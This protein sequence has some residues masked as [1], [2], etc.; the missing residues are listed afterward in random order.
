MSDSQEQIIEA[1]AEAVA[2]GA[3]FIFS[4]GGTGFTASD[5]TPEATK[6]FI[7]REAASLTALIQAESLKITP[8]A[9]LS[10]GICGIHERTL[11]VNAPGKPK[12]VKE[13]WDIL[14]C[15]GVLFHALSQ[16]SQ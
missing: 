7:Q 3:D 12:A 6:F 15:K 11:I 2:L 4:S 1:F 8:M 13:V 9:C 14:T 5:V 10:R 16:L